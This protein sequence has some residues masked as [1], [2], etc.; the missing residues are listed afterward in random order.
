MSHV[1]HEELPGYDV[2][3]IWYDGCDECEKRGAD[4]VSFAFTLDHNR[5][6]RVRQRAALFSL[7]MD[8]LTGPISKAERPLLE[9]AIAAMHLVYGEGWERGHFL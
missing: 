8:D 5:R 6:A 3:Q 7:D 2:R 9:F 4:P 1:F